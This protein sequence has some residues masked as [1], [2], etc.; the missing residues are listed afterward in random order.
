M[1]ECHLNWYKLE[2]ERIEQKL[3]VTANQGLSEG[4]VDERR[5]QY[6]LN[7]IE[8]EKKISKWL[9]FLKQF[10]DYMVL[11]L[12]GA[13]LIAGLLGEYIDTIVIFNIVLVIRVCV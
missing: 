11:V 2:V 6:G 7:Q 9:L 13:T 4:Q 5:E 1:G 12:L 10:Q 8:N 3:H